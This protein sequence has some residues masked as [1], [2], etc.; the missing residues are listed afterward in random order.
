MQFGSARVRRVGW[1]GKGNRRGERTTE[2][3]RE[4][5]ADGDM[6][7]LKGDDIGSFGHEAGEILAEGSNPSGMRNRRGTGQTPCLLT[8]V[9]AWQL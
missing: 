4:R 6:A 3:I 2:C 1:V 7:N 5:M 9:G 8:Q